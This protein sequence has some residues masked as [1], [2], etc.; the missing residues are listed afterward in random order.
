MNEY[1]AKVAADGGLMIGRDNLVRRREYTV[2]QQLEVLALPGGFIVRAHDDH[3][4][5]N[6]REIVSSPEALVAVVTKWAREAHERVPR[7]GERT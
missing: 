7:E 6:V 3:G 1:D 4:E 2:T 5:K